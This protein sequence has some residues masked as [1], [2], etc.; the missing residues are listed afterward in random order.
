MT[1]PEKPEDL[2]AHDSLF[3]QE[4]ASPGPHAAPGKVLDHEPVA[5]PPPAP[6]AKTVVRR[7]GTPLLLT[8][9]IAAGLGGGIYWTWQNPDPAAVQR[10]GPAPAGG[11]FASAASLASLAARVN[12]L[13]KTPLPQAPAAPQPA[14]DPD[15]AAKLQALSDRLDKLEK[16]QAPDSPGAADATVD[17]SKKLDDLSAQVA[18]IS[19]RQDQLAAGLSKV[20]ETA[21][22]KTPDIATPQ[23]DH[24]AEEIA[25][26]AALQAQQQVAD[27]G[28]KTN[29]ALSQTKSSLDALEQRLDKLEQAEHSDQSSAQI[30]ALDTRVGKLEQSEGHL[31]QREG[32]LQGASKDATLAVKFE[33]AQAALSAGKPLGDLPGAPL[34]LQRFATTAP[35]TEAALRAQFGDVSAAILAA[36]RPEE[37]QTSFFSR[38]LARMEQTVTVRQG[39]HVIVGDPAAGV[40]ARA[41]ALLNGGD[42]AGAANALSALTGRAADA[43]KTWREQAQAL[44]AARAALLSMAEHS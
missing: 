44:V 10:I 28:G 12:T 33:A 9:L 37:A 20:Q 18:G 39:D 25:N 11:E 42:L 36:S 3:G 4:A 19:S 30:G 24:A 41:Q 5:P 40:V 13:E 35:P 7:G 8:L 27:L 31:E 21:A 38:A 34:A 23:P 26:A 16:E 14:A 6:P 1:D 22:Q 17:L 2:P 32:Q 15:M 29:T 43:A